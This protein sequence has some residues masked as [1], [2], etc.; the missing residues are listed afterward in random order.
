MRASRSAIAIAAVVAMT[1]LAGCSSSHDDLPDIGAVQVRDRTTP[2]QHV[3]RAVEVDAKP[4]PKP[5]PRP[6]PTAEPTEEPTPE[7]VAGTTLYGPGDNG[8]EVREIQAR[9]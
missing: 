2:A 1:G 8:P 5:K 7:L 6:K 9:L 4:T 3:E